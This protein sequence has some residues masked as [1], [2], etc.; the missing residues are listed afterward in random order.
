MTETMEMEM[1]PRDGHGGMC[2]GSESQ[3]RKGSQMNRRVSRKLC[4]VLSSSSWGLLEVN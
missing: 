1:G 3:S 4:G 2:L